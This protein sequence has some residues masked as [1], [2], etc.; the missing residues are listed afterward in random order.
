MFQIGLKVVFSFF[1]FFILLGL[2]D[3][4]MSV[5]PNIKSYIKYF[6]TCE[7]CVQN[8][9]KMDQDI[10]RDA[11]T[12]SNVVLWLWSA[13]NRVNHR[14]SGDIT[15]DPQHPKIQFPSPDMCA[16]CRLQNEDSNDVKWDE[17]QVLRF[18]RHFYGKQNIVISDTADSDSKVRH[19]SSFTSG[20][21]SMVISLKNVSFYERWSFEWFTNTDISLCVSLYLVSALL[22][23]FIFLL[24]RQ[25]RRKKKSQ[26]FKYTK[27]YP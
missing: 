4:V 15:E 9:F 12:S 13:H 19:H 2:H 20:K 16:S 21:S 1:F 27:L 17:I 7:E 11:N 10:E 22:L 8:F 18:L 6:F 14:L 5:L 25:R 23:V 3:E 24:F 26:I